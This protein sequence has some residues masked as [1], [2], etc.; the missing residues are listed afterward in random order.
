MISATTAYY[1]EELTRSVNYPWH[2]ITTTSPRK[3]LIAL[4]LIITF[5][6]IY[7]SMYGAYVTQLLYDPKDFTMWFSW[8][9]VDI[10]QYYWI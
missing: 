10:A 1:Y 8:S 6:G 5:C 7:F 2:V 3:V 9:V 4:N